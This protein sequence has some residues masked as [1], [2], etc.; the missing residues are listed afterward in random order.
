MSNVL[1]SPEIVRDDTRERVK[2]AIA[3]LGY[4]PHAAAR[5]LRTRRSST[6]GIHL[7]PY[8]GGISGVCSTGSCTP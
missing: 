4:R 1:N 5:R 8:S 3:E 2:Q 7:D 6:I